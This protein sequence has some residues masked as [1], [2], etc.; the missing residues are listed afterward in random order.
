MFSHVFSVSAFS[1][2]FYKSSWHLPCHE[3]RNLHSES[4]NCPTYWRT[5]SGLAHF[6][7]QSR[8]CLKDL[9]GVCTDDPLQCRRNTH[10]HQYI[11]SFAPGITASQFEFRIAD[12]CRTLQ[13]CIQHHLTF[14]IA[15]GV[16]TTSTNKALLECGLGDDRPAQ[17]WCEG[18]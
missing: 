11:L 18:R 5:P 14:G 7:G 13:M 12:D 9:E 3:L 6:P 1:T 10:T 2:V 16:H 17:F 4:A 15:R 8:S